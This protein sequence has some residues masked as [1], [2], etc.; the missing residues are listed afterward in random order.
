M[1][2]CLHPYLIGVPHRIAG[3]DTAVAYI[4]ARDRLE[5]RRSGENCYRRSSA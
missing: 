1:A 3:F 2:I 5:A 4:R